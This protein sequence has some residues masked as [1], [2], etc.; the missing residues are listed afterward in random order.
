MNSTDELIDHLKLIHKITNNNNNDD[1]HINYRRPSFNTLFPCS[2]CSTTFSS[3]FELNQHILHEHT[4][5]RQHVKLD[6]HRNGKKSCK[7]NVYN[8]DIPKNSNE[9][10]RN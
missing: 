9:N 4:G 2:F 10:N 6:W 8:L 3:R 5:E 7:K 1:F